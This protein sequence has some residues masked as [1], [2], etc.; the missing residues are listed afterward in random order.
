MRSLKRSVAAAAILAGTDHHWSVAVEKGEIV[1][2]G[3][4]TVELAASMPVWI[5]IV[6]SGWQ[7]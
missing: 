3:G 6:I 1:L 2:N 5:M 7:K 4:S